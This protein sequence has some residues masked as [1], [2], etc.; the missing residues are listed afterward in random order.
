MYLWKLN[1]ELCNSILVVLVN[2]YTHITCVLIAGS[3]DCEVL[4]WKGEYIC[5]SMFGCCS[6]TKSL[7]QTFVDND[8]YDLDIGY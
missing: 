7:L 4:E 5:L 3:P 1:Q 6:E 8:L 2:V